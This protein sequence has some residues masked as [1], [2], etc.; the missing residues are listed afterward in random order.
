[1][2]LK[3]QLD[4][5]LQI[6]ELNPMSI[7]DLERQAREREAIKAYEIVKQQNKWNSKKKKRSV[8]KE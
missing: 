1:M 5:L 7:K 2:K 3:S 4:I 6:N 8:Q